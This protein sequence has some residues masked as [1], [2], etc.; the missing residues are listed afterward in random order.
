MMLPEKLKSVG[1]SAV[2]ISFMLILGKCGGF[3]REII[4]SHYY[5]TSNITDAYI[6]SGNI[7]GVL[8]GW[9]STLYICFT[10]I[11]LQNKK[12]NGDEKADEFARNVIT[13][14]F[15][16]AVFCVGIVY[17]IPSQLV[18]LIAPGYDAETQ[19]LT[20]KFLKVS[21]LILLIHPVTYPLKSYLE[22]N[23][24]FNKSSVSDVIVSGMQ[25]III[26]LSG[27]L[28]I[29]VLPFAMFVPYLV[30]GICVSMFAR[31]EGFRYYP[32]IKKSD[33]ITTLFRL[34]IPYFISSLIVEI[35]S[36][37]DRYFASSL[38]SGSVAI[39][40]YSATLNSFVMN[41][42]SIALLTIIYPQ[43]A[44][45]IAEKDDVK[46]QIIFNKGLQI[47]S[48]L[49]LPI[50][51]GVMLLAPEL[52]TCVYGHGEFSMDRLGETVNVFRMYAISLSA[53][54]VRELFMRAMYSIKDMKIPI[55]M[56][57]LSAS[58][59]I[60]L[61]M[62]LVDEL[63]AIGLAVST[64]VS[65]VVTIPIYSI[66]AK[67]R[68]NVRINATTFGCIVIA[69]LCSF[70]MGVILYP[71]RNKLLM[72][73]TTYIDNWI[74]LIVCTVIGAI[75]YFAM[76]LFFYLVY[77]KYNGMRGEKSECK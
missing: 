74:V 33:E 9:F 42:F 72:H 1:I 37:I 66:M 23:N 31:K 77:R 32:Q 35:S 64:S 8:F 3:L 75:V 60:I 52:V 70:S 59:N 53:V 11:Y 65:V 44:S 10:P 56:S 71:I 36:M 49:F 76:F 18:R 63:G 62:I 27:K 58:V 2:V 50:T 55:A 67:K 61:N 38:Q 14:F 7:V 68:Q 12:Q 17:C 29:W 21:I 15:V 25:V 39:L 51:V 20:V 45:A 46:Y 4:L 48:F 28:G 41:V 54:A 57:L 13:L 26:G 16:L 6:M 47:I 30:Q 22:C 5:G 34:L 69:L 73:I 24:H 43:M 19:S 40:N